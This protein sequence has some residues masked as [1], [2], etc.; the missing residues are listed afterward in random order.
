MTQL[1]ESL[2]IF[3]RSVAILCCLFGLPGNVLTIIVGIKA[4]F[5]QTIH[6][7]P[8][9]FHLYLIEISVLGKSIKPMIFN[10]IELY[11]ED[12]FHH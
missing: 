8:K 3:R 2:N 11:K 12:N 9:G 6:F 1:N 5:H 4:L 10:H 7:Q